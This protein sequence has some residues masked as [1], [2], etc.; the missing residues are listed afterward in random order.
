MKIQELRR[1]CCNYFDSVNVLIYVQIFPRNSFWFFLSLSKN[2]CNPSSSLGASH[3]PVPL[4]NDIQRQ[5]EKNT[6]ETLVP[7]ET[8]E[9]IHVQYILFISSVIID[10]FD[11]WCFNATFSNISAI[12]W[13]PV[14]SGGRSRRT[15]DHGQ[16]TGKL[17]LAVASGVHPFL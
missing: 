12:S 15:T 17:S 13:R 6:Q 1:S 9:I 2:S 7:S 3:P 8:M 4:K 16:A 14:F 10:W 11:F 5:P